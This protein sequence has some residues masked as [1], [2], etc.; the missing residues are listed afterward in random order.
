MG[1]VFT[2]AGEKQKENYEKNRNNRPILRADFDEN[3]I[4]NAI[5]EYEDNQIRRRMNKRKKN[6]RKKSRSYLRDKGNNIENNFK[7]SFKSHLSHV[8]IEEKE[9][10]KMKNE[11][12]YEDL[13]VKYIPEM[14][15]NSHP[16]G[17]NDIT[18][19]RNMNRG[20]MNG[21]YQYNNSRRYYQGEY[22]GH[23]YNPYFINNPKTRKN[24]ACCILI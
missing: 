9:E 5:E 15:G 17:I 2:L 6:M 14:T 3:L 10:K 23:Q 8:E 16:I 11:P 12:E 7:K 19:T 20:N 21:D 22:Y 24:N 1:S 18:L 13:R 4:G